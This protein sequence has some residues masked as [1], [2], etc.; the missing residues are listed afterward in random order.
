MVHDAGQPRD[1]FSAGDAFI[2]G[3]VREHRAGND[4][5]D[6]PDAVDGGA[7]IMIGLDLTALVR[8]QPRLVEREAVGVR[9]AA[10]RNEDDIGFERFGVASRGGL[11]RQHGLLALHFGPGDL[12]LELEVHAL[13]LEDLVR[14]LAN[15]A[16]HPGQDLVEKLDHGDFRAKPAPDATEF[17]PDHAAADHDHMTGYLRKLERTGRIDDHALVVV[18]FD[19]R[20]RSHRRS[21]GDDDVLG[22]IGLARNLDAVLAGELRIA[23]QPVDLVLL[24]QEFDAAGQA[25]DRILALAVHRAKVEFGRHLDAHRRHRAARRRLEIFRCVEHRLRGDA[26]DV[27]AGAAQRLAPFGARGLEPELRRADRRDI[28]AGTGTDDKDVVVVISH[29]SLHLCSCGRRNPGRQSES[30][31]NRSNHC[32]LSRSISST[33]HARFHFFI[34]SSR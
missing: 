29:G 24:E 3:L 10:D 8:G 6:R 32:G 30:L 13:L 19:A 23:L 4:I 20:K 2:L 9:T 33:F 31:S 26:A 5:A 28:T 17:E 15:V 18:D 27:E 7:E 1:I 25:L 21:G 22:A 12:G 11:E 34:C 16:V 14:F